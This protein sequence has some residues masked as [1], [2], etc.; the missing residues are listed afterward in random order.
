VEVLKQEMMMKP[1]KLRGE[2]ERSQV[3]EGLAVCT[4]EV[5]RLEEQQQCCDR[6][7]QGDGELR[8]KGGKTGWK[9]S[10]AVIGDGRET[11]S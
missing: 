10:S 4:E 1:D 5:E 3:T 11:E 8:V 6:E 2:C 9:N 7:W